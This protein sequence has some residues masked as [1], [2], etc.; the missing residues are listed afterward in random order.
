MHAA[1]QE[2][3]FIGK[4]VAVHDSPVPGKLELMLVS[5]PNTVIPS[6]PDHETPILI[7]SPAA[8][9]EPFG[10]FR[11]LVWRFSYDKSDNQA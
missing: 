9:I 10:S 6:A 8:R 11:F 1:I 5:S 3:L 2:I 4:A 7:I